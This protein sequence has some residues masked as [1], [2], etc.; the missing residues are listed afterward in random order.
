[1]IQRDELNKQGFDTVTIEGEYSAWKEYGN[2][3]ED[4]NNE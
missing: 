1:L 2:K 4:S 3:K